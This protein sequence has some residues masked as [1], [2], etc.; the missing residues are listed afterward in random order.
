MVEQ[1]PHD[2]FIFLLTTSTIHW[3]E[4]KKKTLK[5]DVKSG[6][7]GPAFSFFF[8]SSVK[9]SDDLGGTERLTQVPRAYWSGQVSEIGV[10]GWGWGGEDASLG[11][12][13][14]LKNGVLQ[15]C[16][17]PSR[18]SA[19]PELRKRKEYKDSLAHQEAPNLMLPSLSN[20]PA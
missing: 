3:E 6:Y 8:T 5:G 11:G 4:K 2:R 17:D 13:F 15:P 19:R 18:T 9:K 16:T 7:G 1:N 14:A 10:R 20:R 12:S